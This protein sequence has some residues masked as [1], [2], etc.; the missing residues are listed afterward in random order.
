M[1][2]SAF[3]QELLDIYNTYAEKSWMWTLTL[4]DIKNMYGKWGSSSSNWGWGWSNWWG[5]IN[6][7]SYASWW[8]G[9]SGTGDINWDE[10][11]KNS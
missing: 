11:W 6:I 7:P 10:V 5:W 1:S 9:W 2:E 3:K 4:D 8:W